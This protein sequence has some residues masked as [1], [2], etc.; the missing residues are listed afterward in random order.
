M[1]F[2]P[3]IA[4]ITRLS[5]IFRHLSSSSRRDDHRSDADSSISFVRN[6]RLL[7]VYLKILHSTCT[8]P[9]SLSYLLASYHYLTLEK[10][11]VFAV[12][13]EENFVI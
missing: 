5:H 7:A 2:S 4:G 6:H 8:L 3:T 13:G 9:T 11:S 10:F 1:L 12:V